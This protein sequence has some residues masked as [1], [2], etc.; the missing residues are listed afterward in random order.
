MERRGYCPGTGC[1][2]PDYS[3]GRE[4][5][6]FLLYDAMFNSFMLTVLIVMKSYIPPSFNFIDNKFIKKLLTDYVLSTVMLTV[7]GYILANTIMHKKFFKYKY[8][9]LRAI[10]AYQ[11]I[12]FNIGIPLL[13]IP[14]YQCIYFF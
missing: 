9:G 2:D 7:I 5:T 8:E 14:Y 11:E 6:R 4:K 1:T 3:R 12:L 10:R 13:L